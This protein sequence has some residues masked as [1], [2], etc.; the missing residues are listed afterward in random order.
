VLTVALTHILTV[1]QEGITQR[2]KTVFNVLLYYML[3]PL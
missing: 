2:L 3:W 1:L